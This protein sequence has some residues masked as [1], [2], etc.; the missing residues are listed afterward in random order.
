MPQE[1]N[2]DCS[3]RE[4][5]RQPGFPHPSSPPGG[6]VQPA[7]QSS[8]SGRSRQHG[9]GCP[10]RLRQGCHRQRQRRR[11]FHMLRHSVGNGGRPDARRCSP[12]PLGRAAYHVAVAPAAFLPFPPRSGRSQMTPWA[13][14]A[15]RQPPI[16]LSRCAAQPWAECVS[17]R[18]VGLAPLSP[19][20]GG[21][22]PASSPQPASSV[23]LPGPGSGASGTGD[24]GGSR[25]QRRLPGPRQ[26][27][28]RAANRRSGQRPQPRPGGERHEHRPGFSLC[29]RKVGGRGEPAINPGPSHS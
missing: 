29:R 3:T 28:Q 6:A 10:P 8:P 5:A 18:G 16:Q 15:L 21:L 22:R 27:R 9:P 13:D 11:R 23:A 26:Q 19:T 17:R 12:I 25:R 14:C 2:C 20:L 1:T 7:S 4:T 24:N